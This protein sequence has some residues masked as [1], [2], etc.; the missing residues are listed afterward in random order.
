MSCVHPL[1]VQVMRRPETDGRVFASC[2]EDSLAGM[3]TDAL[4]VSCVSLPRARESSIEG[5]LPRPV[6]DHDAPFSRLP[7]LP[8]AR[9]ARYPALSIRRPPVLGKRS[10]RERLGGRM[11]GDKRLDEGM[12][13]NSLT[14]RRL[15]LGAGRVGG[16]DKIK[17]GVVDVMDYVSAVHQLQLT[18]A[19]CRQPALRRRIR[20]SEPEGIATSH[21][22]LGIN[23][24]QRH[25]PISESEEEMLSD[26]VWS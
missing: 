12:V 19:L 21:K 22:P 14:D 5:P 17:Q 10:S 4:D 15:P 20:P 6:L 8:E 23:L 26:C 1:A 3:P 16:R 25:K 2:E 24:S 18:P 7:L 13:A 9:P 11:F